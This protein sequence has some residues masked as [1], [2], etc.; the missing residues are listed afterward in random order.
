MKYFKLFSM[1]LICTF[2]LSGCQQ[3][4]TQ[5]PISKSGMYFDTVITIQILDSN[6]NSILEDC[7]QLCAEY[8]AKFS[9][10]IETSEVSQINNA[11]GV[12]VTVSA[13]T[14]ELIKKGLY[15]SELSEGAFD[16]TISPLS[17][18]WDFK[19]KKDHKGTIPDSTTIN[20]AISHVDY[21]NVLISGN[22]VTLTDPQASI[23]LGGIAKGYI[24]DCLK[25]YLEEQGIKH[26]LINLGGNVLTIG[27]KMDGTDYKI[28]IQKPFDKQ[29]SAITSV[30]VHDKSV[31]S[32]GVYER[33]FKQDDT[34]YHHIL[35]PATGYP[36]KNELLGVTIIS[37]R[38]TDGDGLSTTC[39]ALGLDKG[40]ALINELDNTE[41]IFITDDYKLHYSAGLDAK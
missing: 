3:K 1:L 2:F 29:N 14:I 32:S 33:Y 25:A 38:S 41:A 39:F 10:K 12:P 7:F 19:D 20:E 22:T 11:S 9:N 28:G 27:T 16:I 6:D 4:K 34:L 13:D 36:Y 35:N 8:E 17:V 5:E 31:V 23:D 24:A 21:R 37:Q 26:A 30:S 40:L 18:L 15:Y